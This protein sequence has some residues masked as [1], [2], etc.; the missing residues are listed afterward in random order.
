MSGWIVSN[1]KGDKF[2]C[3]GSFGP[4]WTEDRELATR[5]A[6]RRDAES[7][8]ENDDDAWRIILVSEELHRRSDQEKEFALLSEI[9]ETRAVL[10][11]LL[12]VRNLSPGTMEVIEREISTILSIARDRIGSGARPSRVR[13]RKRRSTYS[14]LGDA[15]A[16]IA[17][18]ADGTEVPID[19]VRSRLLTEGD[20]LV[21]YRADEGGKL[22]L[23]F[24]DEFN[25]G[26][27]EEIPA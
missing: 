15:E 24:P 21:V 19:R 16:Q 26:R 3:W 22:W 20:K 7:V 2:R 17:T 6:R 12:S 1:A 13:H 8:H 9:A 18:Y 5:Y 25:D 4:D 11:H 23:R 27:F 10:A 14:V